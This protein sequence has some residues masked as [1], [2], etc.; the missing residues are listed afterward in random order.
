MTEAKASSL[1]TSDVQE[2]EDLRDGEQVEFEVR[3]GHKGLKAVDVQRVANDV[4]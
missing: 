2:Q 4:F 3:E 1:T